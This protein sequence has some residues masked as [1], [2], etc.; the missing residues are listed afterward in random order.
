MLIV[1]DSFSQDLVNIIHEG[2]LFERA[3]IRV[4][5][6]PAR[7]QVYKGDDPITELVELSSAALCS[8]DYYEGLD[9]LL[10]EADAILVAASWREKSAERLPVTLERLG[11]AA[12]ENYIIFGR[13]SLGYINRAAYV[14]WML[15]E[16]ATY[17]NP[18]NDSSS[19]ARSIRCWPIHLGRPFLLRFTR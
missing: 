4:R 15:D 5:Y 18:V 16:K 6:I 1:G 7:C 17:S 2:R 8:R 12:K 11:I 19:T 14:G 13:K 3:R 10:A 9:I